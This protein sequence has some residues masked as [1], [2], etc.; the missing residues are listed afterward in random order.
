MLPWFHRESHP[1]DVLPQVLSQCELWAKSCIAMYESRRYTALVTDINVE[2]R[3][4]LCRFLGPVNPP[5]I[6]PHPGSNPRQTVEIAARLK[7]R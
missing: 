1:N 3:L 5:D 2:G 6:V 4:L 7:Y